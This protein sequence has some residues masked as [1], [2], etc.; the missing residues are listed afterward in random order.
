MRLRTLFR[1]SVFQLTLV[2]M[3]L[4]AV[5]AVGLLAF[6]YWST[7]GYIER[8]TNAVIEAEIEGLREQYPLQGLIEAIDARVRDE[9]TNAPYICSRTG[10]APAE[11]ATCP[12]GRASWT[13][14]PA[15]GSTSRCTT[16]PAAKSRC[17]R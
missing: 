9:P 5:S 16:K 6:I 13:P 10:S 2:Y 15:S 1:T 17:A 14:M 8:Q 11:R 12:T 7:F 4:F 3:A